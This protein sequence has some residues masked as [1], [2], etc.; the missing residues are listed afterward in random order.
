MA[1]DRGKYLKQ[2]GPLGLAYVDEDNEI[3]TQE[4]VH[5]RPGGSVNDENEPTNDDGEL[6]LTD[7]VT[8]EVPLS[9][10]NSGFLSIKETADNEIELMD[11]LVALENN[12]KPIILTEMFRDMLPVRN[13]IS[14]G[15]VLQAGRT[16][17]IYQSLTL[18]DNP[19]NVAVNTKI[20][21][22]YGFS[23][24]TNVQESCVYDLKQVLTVD[25]ASFTYVQSVSGYVSVVD[26]KSVLTLQDWNDEIEDMRLDGHVEFARWKKDNLETVSI[27]DTRDNDYVVFLGEDNFYDSTSEDVVLYRN[28]I[29]LAKDSHYKFVDDAAVVGNAN[30]TATA[31]INRYSRKIALIGGMYDDGDEID[32]MGN[33]VTPIP[34]TPEVVLRP[35]PPTPSIQ[36]DPPSRF[37]TGELMLEKRYNPDEGDMW[38]GYEVINQEPKEEFEDAEESDFW[39]DAQGLSVKSVPLFGKNVIYLKASLLH[40][41]APIREGMGDN[42]TKFR[43][44]DVEPDDAGALRVLAETTVRNNSVNTTATDNVV[45]DAIDVIEIDTSDSSQEHLIKVSRGNY[46]IAKEPVIKQYK[47]QYYYSTLTDSKEALHS[48]LGT[49]MTYEHKE[50]PVSKMEIM[51]FDL[52]QNTFFEKGVV[53]GQGD[54]EMQVNFNE[55]FGDD[56][57]SL[58]FTGSNVYPLWYEDKSED[59]FKL[60]SSGP[61]KGSVRWT[62]VRRLTPDWNDLGVVTTPDVFKDE[63]NLVESNYGNS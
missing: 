41:T 47:V 9:R 8:D 35:V 51:V 39:F 49:A 52:F 43:I 29:K 1:N 3:Q 33:A 18:D 12:N 56:K 11:D 5:L 13:V 58:Q 30:A 24:G 10:L 50:L 36:L 60:K 32:A 55:P 42:I 20:A 22:T 6:I 14:S 61:I 25:V 46:L 54:Q 17:M 63:G 15:H 34:P 38:W 53:V 2:G 57:Y 40:S 27:T 19:L 4:F 59:G 16:E 37:P 7:N 62:A 44:I 23:N 31:L 21:D 48:F 45:L 26:H 28:G